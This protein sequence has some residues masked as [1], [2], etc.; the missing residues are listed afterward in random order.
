MKEI[1]KIADSLKK[2]KK[3]N[4]LGRLT[5]KELYKA[6]ELQSELE[7]LGL[8]DNELIKEIQNKIKTK[9]EIVG[10]IEGPRDYNKPG[11]TSL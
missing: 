3:W 1:R 9:G 8:H 7:K 11:P 4:R 10:P 5:Y 6:L 2:S